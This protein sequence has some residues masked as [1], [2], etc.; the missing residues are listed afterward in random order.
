MLLILIA[1]LALASTSW[2]ALAPASE[3]GAYISLLS[4]QDLCLGRASNSSGES[5]SAVNLGTGNRTWTG[6]RVGLV[7][8]A[9]AEKWLVGGLPGDSEPL[10]FDNGT[11]TA[12]PVGTNGI[13]FADATEIG[14]TVYDYHPSLQP[15]YLW[16]WTTDS[17]LQ[18]LAAG[19][20]CIEGDKDTKLVTPRPCADVS[21]QSWTSRRVT[22]SVNTSGIATSPTYADPVGGSRIHALSR[23]DLCVTIQPASNPDTPDDYSGS[24]ANSNGIAIATCVPNDNSLSGFQLFAL[25]LPGNFSTANYTGPL[26]IIN[27]TAV[28]DQSRKYCLTGSA[29]PRNGSAILVQECNSSPGQQWIANNRTISLQN[30]GLVGVRAGTFDGLYI[31]LLSAENLCLSSIP[32]SGGTNQG[33]TNLGTGNRTWTGTRVGL[34]DCSSADKWSNARQ[35]SSGPLA[36]WTKSL[37]AVPIGQDGFD[38]Q[39]S[40][41]LGIVKYNGSEFDQDPY[42]WYWGE[43]SHLHIFSNTDICIEADTKTKA[44]TTQPCSDKASQS[45]AFRSTVTLLNSSSIPIGTTY[46]DPQG[47]SR[48][49]AL[50]RNDLC[51]S[52]APSSDPTGSLAPGDPIYVAR[53]L[54]NSNLNVGFQL[55]ALALPGD[56]ST[57]NYTGALQVMNSTA[58]HDRTQNL[59]LGVGDN[60]T[61]GSNLAVQECNASPGQ[62]WLAD[63]STISVQDTNMCLDVVRGSGTPPGAEGSFLPYFTLQM[64]TCNP[65][66]PQ[67]SQNFGFYFAPT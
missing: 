40:T 56:F 30:T 10:R 3:A 46:P 60:P 64:W 17:Q 38:L 12:V 52:V 66:D 37:A 23:D 21:A 61:N 29:K 55:F 35:G 41:G 49:R 58:I 42:L 27:S 28:G 25:A 14:F 15:G 57:A 7:D 34:T 33:V 13:D 59:C 11:L 22:G 19:N 31:S 5:S 32:D 24:I 47:G 1:I 44:V 18:F 16:Y 45:F 50:G 51:V 63:N 65:G 8:C 2:A 43:D 36:I 62:H 53:C 20:I 54:D 26:Q 48:I 9:S 6:L 39:N 67:Q 4:S